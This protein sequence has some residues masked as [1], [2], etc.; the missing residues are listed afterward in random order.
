MKFVSYNYAESNLVCL[1]STT[2]FGVLWSLVS[3]QNM[4]RKAVDSVLIQGR[5]G[6][7]KVLIICLSQIMFL[8]V[9]APF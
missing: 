6:Q 5:K 8:N 3:M 2:F 4:P 9:S 7:E 1:K